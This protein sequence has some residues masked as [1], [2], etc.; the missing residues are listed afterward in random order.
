M[1]HIFMYAYM[2]F[3][4]FNIKKL[5]RRLTSPRLRN[6]IFNNKQWFSG[7]T[8]GLCVTKYNNK[9]KLL[10]T[11]TCRSNC[12]RMFV[13]SKCDISNGV[14][15]E[16]VQRLYQTVFYLQNIMR[17]HFKCIRVIQFTP[18][19]KVL[20]FLCWFPRTSYRPNGS[21]STSLLVTNFT[22]IG[23]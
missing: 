8:Q 18:K 7:H 12:I 15:H 17:F 10:P 6:C 1:K 5:H 3:T 21:T 14:L 4:R 9:T 22:T 13:K 11:S 20:P 16:G 23:K 2:S 19:W